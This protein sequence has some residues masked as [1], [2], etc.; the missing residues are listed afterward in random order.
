MKENLS[1]RKLLEV[2]THEI[3]VLRKSSKDIN[4][5]G[6]IISKKLQELEQT[7]LIAEIDYTEVKLILNEF[8]QF[9]DKRIV[10]PRWF[11]ALFAFLIGILAMQSFWLYTRVFK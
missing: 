3:E 9:I 5:V 8:K 1:Q 10:F 4:K 2:L 6:P 7:K 11:L